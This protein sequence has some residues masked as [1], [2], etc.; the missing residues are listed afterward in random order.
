MKE[1]LIAV[2][3]TLNGISVQGKDNLDRLLGSI[4]ALEKLLKE[5]SEEKGEENG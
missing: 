3:N 2:I 1:M 4:Q 5:Q